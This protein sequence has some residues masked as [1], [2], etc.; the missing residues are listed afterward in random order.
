[1]ITGTITCQTKVGNG[2]KENI[3]ITLIPK[4]VKKFLQFGLKTNV[5][6]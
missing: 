4:N 5:L 1:M 6:E 2:K 3:R